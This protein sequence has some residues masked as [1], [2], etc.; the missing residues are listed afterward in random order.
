V[1]DHSPSDVAADGAGNRAVRVSAFMSRP[2]RRP[3]PANDNPVPR[4]VLW[5]RRMRLVLLLAA[6]AVL[7]WAVLS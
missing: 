3:R 1:A 7:A 6:A 4:R 2:P 5:M